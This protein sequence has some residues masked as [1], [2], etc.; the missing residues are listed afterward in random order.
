MYQSSCIDLSSPSKPTFTLQAPENVMLWLRKS[1]HQISQPIVF[2][3]EVLCDHVC[4]GRKLG[5][6][7][8]GQLPRSKISIKTLH[9]MSLT[10]VTK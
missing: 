10:L 4:Q 9:E 1:A 6:A 2:M 3:P 8:N 5:D 7:I